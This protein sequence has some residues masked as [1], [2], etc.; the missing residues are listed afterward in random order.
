MAVKRAHITEVR[1]TRPEDGEFFATTT[2]LAFDSAG[3]R[4]GSTSEAEA[5][6]LAEAYN[7]PRKLRQLEAA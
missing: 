2:W 3:R 5:R 4:F 6:D 7:A 1:P